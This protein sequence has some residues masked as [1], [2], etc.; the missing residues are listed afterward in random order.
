M[1]N[2]F[3]PYYECGDPERQAEIDMCLRQNAN[4]SLIDRLFVLIDDDSVCPVESPNL[5]VIYV[6]K[7]V[8]YKF[9]IELTKKY[10]VKGISVLCNSD[11][12][13]DDSLDKLNTVLSEPKSFLALSRW[14]LLGGETSKHPN[15]HWSQDT[16]AINVMDELSDSLMHQLDFPMGVPRCDNKIAYLFAVFGWKVFNPVDYV[17]S[18]HAHETQMRTYHKKMDER[19][20]G[21]VAYVHPGEGVNAEATLDFDVWIKRADTKINGVKIN[22]TLERWQKEAA[23]E[24]G[25]PKNIEFN[26]L[27]LVEPCELLDAIKKGDAEQVSSYPY[28]LIAY[29]GSFYFN[30]LYTITHRHSVSEKLYNENKQLYTLAGFIPPVLDTYVNEINL[31]PVDKR[32]INFWQYPCATEKQA[33]ENHLAMKAGDNIDVESKSVNIYVP[34]PWATYVDKKAFPDE[35]LNKIKSLLSSY[36]ELVASFGYT[37]KVHSVCQ[38]IHWVRMLEKAEWLGITDF[39]LSHKDSKSEAIQDEVGTN[40]ALHGWTLIAVNY[41]T[42]E[43]NEGMERKAMSERNLL[44][45]FIGAH[46]KHYRDDS[47]IKL[48]E[49][50]KAYGQD[51]VLVDLGNEWHFNKVV[52]EEQVLNKEIESHHIDEHHKRTFRYNT[53]LS[54]S[55]FSLCPEGAGP[56]TL[57]FWESIAVGSIPVIFSDDLEIFKSAAGKKLLNLCIYYKKGIDSDLFQHL[58][59]LRHEDVKMR[60]LEIIKLYDYFA[61]FK[62][63]I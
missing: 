23:E 44:A 18:I 9:W 22:K 63:R 16:W 39:Y 60:S 35:Y 47:R 6:D 48:F 56:N 19:I 58:S 3:F 27:K 2:V 7:R 59:N 57:R 26:A 41:E 40:L 17:K 8:T 5:D 25:K 4:N 14:E 55:K 42:P 32:D 20:L 38:H 37:L 29:K 61:K 1:I 15:P 54:D 10:C 28:R 12:Y 33:F 31:K 45:S 30:N 11:I 46:M 62:V 43:R 36:R 21:G 34:L 53:I 50:A 51:D 24:Q 13:F 52:Y 49:A